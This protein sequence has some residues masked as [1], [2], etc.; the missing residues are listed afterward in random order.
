MK[1]ISG[2]KLCKTIEAKGWK[3]KRINGSHHVYSKQGREELIVIPVH[4]NYNIKIGLLKSI[5]RIADI[6][7]NEL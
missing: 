2:K 1:T 6:N 3:L 4:K 5:M 7:E